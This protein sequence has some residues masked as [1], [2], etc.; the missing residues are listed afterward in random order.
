MNS[1][2]VSQAVFDMVSMHKVDILALVETKVNGDR[3]YV[4]C[5]MLH[6]DNWLRVECF[7][8]SGGIWLF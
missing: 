8:F 6:F 5:S 7:G 1:Q 3:A 2:E 4:I